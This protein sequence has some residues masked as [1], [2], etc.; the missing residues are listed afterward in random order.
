MQPRAR[1]AA[2]QPENDSQELIRTLEQNIA[3]DT[4]NNKLNFEPAI[5]AYFVNQSSHDF[6]DEAAA[7]SVNQTSPNPYLGNEA[8]P[9]SVDQASFG[10]Q[11]SS[12]LANEPAP[13]LVN[14]ESPYF[15]NGTTPNFD[16]LN[17]AIYDKL[18]RTPASDPWLGLAPANAF[19]ALKNGGVQNAAQLQQRV[20]QNP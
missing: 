14:R 4:Q 2:M 18:F 7:F 6:V 3:R 20:A 19:V 11:K 1:I 16:K 10:N 9:K 17:R 12:P 15:A 8:A 5:H 13:N